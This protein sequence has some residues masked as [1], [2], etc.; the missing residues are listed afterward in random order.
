MF[1]FLAVFSQR[2]REDWG[3]KGIERVEGVE[4]MFPGGAD[5]KVCLSTSRSSFFSWEFGVSF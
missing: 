2:E 5:L 4:T 1:C 3:V